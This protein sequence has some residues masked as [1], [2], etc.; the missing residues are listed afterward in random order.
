MWDSDKGV[1]VGTFAP[2]LSQVLNSVEGEVVGIPNACSLAQCAWHEHEHE[3]RE[4]RVV[5]RG[6]NSEKHSLL[7]PLHMLTQFKTYTLL[8][9]STG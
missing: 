2:G 3:A 8:W 6:E 7:P 9:R 5:E 4:N 1:T